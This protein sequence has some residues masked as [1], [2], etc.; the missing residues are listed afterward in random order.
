MPRLSA[1]AHGVLSLQVANMARSS[2]VVVECL[3]G[4]SPLVPSIILQA[5]LWC[6][7]VTVT[8]DLAGHDVPLS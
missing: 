5:A 8:A 3:H 6:V 4:A 2:L 1:D 7:V